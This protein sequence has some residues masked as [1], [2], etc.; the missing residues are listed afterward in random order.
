MTTNP[1]IAAARRGGV[2]LFKTLIDFDTAIFGFGRRNGTSDVLKPTTTP[3]QP[4]FH[5]GHERETPLHSTSSSQG[6]VRSGKKFR[7]TNIDL[8]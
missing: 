5:A 3:P 4:S 1:S 2:P 6:R 7:A 8:N